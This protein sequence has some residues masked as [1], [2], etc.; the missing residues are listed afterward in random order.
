[1]AMS[2]NK[3]ARA[4]P[5]GQRLRTLAQNRGFYIGAAVNTSAFTNNEAS[6]I[7]TLKGEYNVLVAEI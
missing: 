4:A 1:M 6:Y 3:T 7:D 2:A 5:S